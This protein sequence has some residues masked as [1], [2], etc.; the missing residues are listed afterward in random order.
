MAAKEIKVFGVRI[1]TA[2]FMKPD[3]VMIIPQRRTLEPDEEYWHRCE[4]QAVLMRAVG[5]EKGDEGQ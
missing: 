4:T 5:R 1:I 2:D 3:E